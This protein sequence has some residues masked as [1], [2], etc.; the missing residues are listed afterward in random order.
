M[1]KV[2]TSLILSL[3]FTFT[4]NADQSYSSEKHSFT[5]ETVVEGLENPWSVDFLPDGR[6]LVTE[7]PGRLRI[8]DNGQLSE[9]VKG[10]PKVK[11]KGQ[12]GLLDIALDPSFADNQ[13][14]YFSYSAADKTGI[15]TEVASAKLVENELTQVK[16]LF[17][18][19]PKS[20]GGNHFGSRLLID[21]EG[22]LFI[23]LG[24]RG[25]KER[26]QDIDDHAGFSYS[27]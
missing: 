10:L 26:A 16:V 22:K 5:V 3:C 27:N 17:K 21:K 23:T 2:I 25:T 1:N 20:R 4:I 13:I 18:A 15:G 24:E 8:V 14:L 12:G 7:R 19:L 9:P 11:A 6:I